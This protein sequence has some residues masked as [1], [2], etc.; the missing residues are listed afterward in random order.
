MKQQNFERELPQG[1]RQ[2]FYLNAK[3]VKV[4]VI[5]NL[6]AIAV[7]AVVMMIAVVA[8]ALLADEYKLDTDPVRALIALWVFLLAMIAY[9]VLHELVHGIA[10][11]SLTGEKLTYG[12]SWSCAFCGVP[13]IYTCRKTALVALVAPLIVFSVVLGGLCVWMF[14]VDHWFYFMSAF[15]L[16]LHLGGCSGDIYMMMVLSK[17]KDPKLLMKDTGP[18]QTLYLPEEEK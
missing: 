6:V 5:L 8:L 3:S 12:I 13:N 9:I 2:V 18:E 1:Y 11:K 15:L 14:F 7:L 16:G 10:Y 4:G 17:Y